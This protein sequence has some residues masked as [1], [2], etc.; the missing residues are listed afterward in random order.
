MTP[1]C[2]TC[3]E[4]QDLRP[5]RTRH[6]AGGPGSTVYACPRHAAAYPPEPDPIEVIESILRARGEPDDEG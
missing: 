4:R 3:D 5:V 6:G 2:V 1:Y